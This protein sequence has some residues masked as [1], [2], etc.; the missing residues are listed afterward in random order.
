MEAE[1]TSGSISIMSITAPTDTKKKADLLAISDMPFLFLDQNFKCIKKNWLMKQV[2]ENTTGIQ[3][4]KGNFSIN[5][6]RQIEQQNTTLPDETQPALVYS[7]S[8]I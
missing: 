5:C 2:L 7:C 1:M 3:R 6:L 4:Y 8:G